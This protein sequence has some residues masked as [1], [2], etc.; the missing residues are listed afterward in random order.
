VTE[1]T[2]F[3]NVQNSNHVTLCLL[4]SSRY[5]ATLSSTRKRASV[6]TPTSAASPIHCWLCSGKF[7]CYYFW[8]QT[9]GHSTDTDSSILPLGWGAI[10]NDAWNSLL[11][12]C[13][14][15]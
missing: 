3:S 14:A 13:T 15:Q 4:T 2:V 8:I 6:V 11:S 10:E 1:I 5:L 12:S 7:T 9:T